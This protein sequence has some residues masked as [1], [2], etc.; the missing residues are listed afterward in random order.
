MVLCGA[1]AKRIELF[2]FMWFLLMEE[3]VFLCDYWIR[4]RF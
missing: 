2:G 1:R 4:L 3:D